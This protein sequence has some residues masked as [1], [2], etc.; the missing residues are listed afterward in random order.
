MLVTDIALKSD[1]VFG[2]FV[3]KFFPA[4]RAAFPFTNLFRLLGF[5]PTEW[6]IDQPSIPGARLISRTNFAT[7]CRV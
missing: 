7:I 2:I 5:G 4:Q 6:Q 1:L 3:G